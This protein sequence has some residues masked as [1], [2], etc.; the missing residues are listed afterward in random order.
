M[1]IW[2][3][4]SPGGSTYEEFT[5][6]ST[7][8]STT[9]RWYIKYVDDSGCETE[10]TYDV[11]R[12]CTCGDFSASKSSVS[13][14]SG[15]G[16]D[17]VTFSLT[18]SCSG[19]LSDLTC[20][21]SDS[22]I[23]TGFNSSH[24]ALTITVGS[25]SDYNTNRTG[26]TVVSYGD[27]NVVNIEVV[28]EKATPGGCTCDN[29]S[30][31]TSSVSFGSSS[32]STTRSCYKT[33]TCTGEINQPSVTTS[34]G[35]DW[36]TASHNGDTITI[37]VSEYSSGSGDRTAT[38]TPKINN[39]SCSSKAITVTQSAPVYQSKE[40][41]FRI[42]GLSSD[43]HTDYQEVEFVKYG[44]SETFIKEHWYNDCLDTG[45]TW[46]SMFSEYCVYDV[47]LIEHDGTMTN[48]ADILTDACGVKDTWE[49]GK[50]IEVYVAKSYGSGSSDVKKEGSFSIPAISY[51]DPTE[52]GIIYKD[53]Y[54]TD[55]PKCYNIT[56]TSGNVSGNCTG[57]TVGFTAT[58]KSCS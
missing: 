1:A 21:S 55:S 9:G 14:G 12:C 46:Y 6:G 54:L 27:C 28:Q 34:D 36:C 11:T 7:T 57:G 58:E 32:S 42:Y 22:W 16:E 38:V 47:G 29:L 43:V 53:I 19:S 44:S 37:S 23:T 39:S 49:V 26:H 17:T 18:G 10:S 41:R 8:F 3:R 31:D 48:W 2:Y 51:N 13:F 20:T 4:K 52:G 24:S 25:Y 56:P 15:G 50:T 5:N 45:T 40:V 33:G 35:G 30:V